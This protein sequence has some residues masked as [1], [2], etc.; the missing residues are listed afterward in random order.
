MYSYGGDDMRRYTLLD[1]VA[2]ILM[3]VGALNWGLIALFDFNVVTALL[4]DGTVL[5]R[6]VYA[7]V[8]LSALY[9]LFAAPSLVRSTE[10]RLS[11]II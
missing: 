11:G 6:L 10:R 2:F 7:L 3:S 5:S 9:F 1:T 8:G 4:G